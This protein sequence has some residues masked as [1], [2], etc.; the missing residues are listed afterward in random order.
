M[1]QWVVTILTAM[2]LA[3]SV[4]WAEVALKDNHPE[5][6][7]VQPGDTLWDISAKFLEKPWLWPEIWQVNPQVQNPHL[8]YPGDVLSLV[9]IDGKPRLVRK[10]GIVKLSPKVREISRGQ[11]VAPLP[12]EYVKP[13]LVGARIVDK[14]QLDKAPYVVASDGDH[15]MA[16]VGVRV[17]ARG[18][19]KSEPLQ[20]FAI[21]RPGSEYRDPKTG[22]ILGF[23]AI[24]VGTA[25]L[26]RNGDPA[27]LDITDSVKE[28]LNGDRLLPIDN[29]YLVP[30]FYPRAPE[31]QVEGQ[32]ISVYDGVTQIGQYHVVVINRGKREGMMPGHV[33]TIWSR[34][35]TI[36]DRVAIERRRQE[37]G[38]NVFSEI[39]EKLT[40]TNEQEQVTLPDEEAG[41]L[42]IFRV[43]DKVSLALVMRATRPI[44][45]QDPVRSPY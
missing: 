15:L 8:I 4:S 14:E 35:A 25:Q 18:I 19:P 30:E 28:A 6:Y 26:K 24:H 23:E 27:T 37:D 12:L 32:I 10:P 20:N 16:G 44:H 29:T 2:L 39:G 34:G 36:K 31:K 17:Y 38:Y 1:K 41:E 7:V 21:F 3:S 40:G 45:V 22:E 43:F 33:L 13:F 11:A 5:V 42:M 9:Y